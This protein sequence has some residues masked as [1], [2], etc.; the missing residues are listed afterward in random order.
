MNFPPCLTE[1]P[2]PVNFVPASSPLPTETTTQGEVRIL[3][4]NAEVLNYLMSVLAS[5]G[6][7]C[8]G[9]QNID[10]FFDHGTSPPTCVLVD[11]RLGSDDGL[12]VAARCREQWPGAAVIL[13][14]G[15]ATVPVAVNAM[16][17]GVDGVLQ[18]PISPADLLTEIYAAQERSRERTAVTEEQAGARAKIQKLTKCEMEILKL[19]AAGVPNK[20]I[21]LKL[22]LAVRTIEKHRR[23]LFE[24]LGVDSAAE[25]TRI[26]VLANLEE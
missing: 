8:H 15:Y 5:A 26:F 2:Q 3:D 7:P 4:D 21:A 12:K 9:F 13:I 14:S 6:V 19:L 11:W 17:Q 24:N 1:W 18:K 22:S 16:R 20:N 10:G 25:A 23:L